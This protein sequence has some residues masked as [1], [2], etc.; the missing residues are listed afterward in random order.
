MRLDGGQLLTV[1][2]ATYDRNDIRL[3]Y[4]V[5][6]H[7]AQGATVEN[8]YVFSHGAMIDAQLAYVQAS[9]ARDKTRIYTTRDE[10]GPGLSDLARHGRSRKKA[11]PTTRSREE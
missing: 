10:A 2:L 4:C 3:G 8:A 5:T 9:R 7:K 11:W 1:A 6:T